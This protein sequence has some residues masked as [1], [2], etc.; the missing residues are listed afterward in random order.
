MKDKNHSHYW[1]ED[2]KLYESYNTLR[3]L[4]YRFIVGCPGIQNCKKCSDD[5]VEYL[6]KEFKV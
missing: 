4:R 3:G 1:V 2:E 5:M 6:F